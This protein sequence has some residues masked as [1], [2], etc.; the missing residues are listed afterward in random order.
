MSE[1]QGLMVLG[2]AFLAVLGFGSPA[3]AEEPTE[4]ESTV[5][6]P[7]ESHEGEETGQA[8]P[9]PADRSDEPETGTDDSDVSDGTDDGEE[10]YGFRI[11][12]QPRERQEPPSAPIEETSIK[13]GRDERDAVQVVNEFWV[14]NWPKNFTGPYKPPTVLGPY[15]PT[16]PDRPTCGDEPLGAGEAIYCDGPDY[17]AWDK[18]FIR[19]IP[20][21]EGNTFPYLVVAHEWGHA[22]QARI[23]GQ[24]WKGSELQADC[25]AGAT[26]VGAY[27]EGRLE[28]EPRDPE[29][30]SRALTR[31]ADS[32]PWSEPEHHGD[33]EQRV[34]YFSMGK[35]GVQACVQEH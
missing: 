29:K 26:L 28:W 22:I 34:H 12:P 4:P 31:I 9:A 24:V 1:K 16:S 14:R 23:P 27:K 33:A 30:L 2:P 5:T 21:E 15:D 20:S 8:E 35:Q 11:P 13:M 3:L 10:P 6:A 18:D 25:L 32:H 19:G 17:I 7:A